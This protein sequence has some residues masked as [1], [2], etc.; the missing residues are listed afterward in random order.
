MKRSSYPRLM[1]A[2]LTL[3]LVVLVGF[4]CFLTWREVRQER[5][6][7]QLIDAIK[8]EDTATALSVLAQGADANAREEFSRPLWE[9]I[10]NR[11]RGHASQTS[12]LPTAL[13]EVVQRRYE[14]RGGAF[15][16]FP[17]RE[18]V[19]LFSALLT[20]GAQVDVRGDRGY[21]PLE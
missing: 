13:Q 2:L 16:E 8:R 7:Q 12:E 6:N 19:P 4:P 20:Q 5:L 17:S 18:N 10:W 9:D 3:A 21:T 11:L 15:G 1:L 14:E